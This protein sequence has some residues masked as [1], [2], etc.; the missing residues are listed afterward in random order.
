MTLTIKN[1]VLTAGSSED[2]IL[3]VRQQRIVD[4]VPD[5]W[6]LFDSKF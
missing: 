1:M 5:H 3:P 2:S 4:Q 6:A